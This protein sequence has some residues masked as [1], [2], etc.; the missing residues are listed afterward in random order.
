MPYTCSLDV[1]DDHP[2]GLDD[3]AVGALLNVTKQCINAEQRPAW[4]VVKQRVRVALEL[5][6]DVQGNEIGALF[7]QPNG[8]G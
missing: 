3:A 8:W 4:E 6:V 2:E 7:A 1:V 5:E